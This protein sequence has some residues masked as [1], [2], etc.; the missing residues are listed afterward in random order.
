MKKDLNDNLI[1][2]S[3]IRQMEVIEISTGK[4]LGFISDIIFDD[5]FTRI[6]SLVLPPDGGF[7]GLFKKKDEVIIPW[8]DIK[9]LGIDVILIERQKEKSNDE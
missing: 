7:F 8:E 9:T 1:A 3:Q 4:R 2:L 6:E 5:D